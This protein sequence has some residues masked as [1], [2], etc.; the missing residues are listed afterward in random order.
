MRENTHTAFSRPRSQYRSSDAVTHVASEDCFL[1]EI[2]KETQ[3][4]IRLLK[5][6]CRFCFFPGEGEGMSRVR[7]VLLQDF[8]TCKGL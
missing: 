5:N 1:L 4:A 6:D 8:A 2:N 3:N 7:A